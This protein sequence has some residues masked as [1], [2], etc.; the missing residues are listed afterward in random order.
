VRRC[1]FGNRSLLKFR[2]RGL[3]SNHGL[4]C[5]SLWTVAVFGRLALFGAW[6]WLFKD[7]RTVFV[8]FCSSAFFSRAHFSS[9]VSHRFSVLIKTSTMTRSTTAAAT[10]T[11]TNTH[12]QT[13]DDSSTSS[14][15][16]KSFETK[17]K[18]IK[19]E[20]AKKISSL[21]QNAEDMF[22][23]YSDANCDD[24]MQDPLRVYDELSTVTT[25]M[26]NEWK[27][28]HSKIASIQREKEIQSEENE[29][30]FREAYMNLVTEAFADELDDLRQGL[31]RS[32]EKE[33]EVP[34]ILKQ[35]NIVMPEEVTANGDVDVN[36]LI[37][38][39][40][41]GMAGW[42]AD[43][44]ELLLLDLKQRDDG[45]RMEMEMDVDRLTPHE[46]RRREL[47]GDSSS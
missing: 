35:D 24:L 25:A 20:S 30:T 38:M 39:L 12:T 40:E 10:A 21:A 19:H 3:L 2:F 44:K 28:F 37:E 33:K 42:T 46:K 18:A 45:D 15:S 17:L 36:I 41:S 1:W 13:Q 22:E 27:D 7:V 29:A 4:I 11:A 14:S 32:T 34:D 31:I 16:T 5:V 6:F 26:S 23:K 47:F 43:E 9:F 8:P